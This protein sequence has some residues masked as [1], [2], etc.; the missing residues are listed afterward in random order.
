MIDV[1]GYAKIVDLGFAKIILD[2]SYT[3]C[4]SEYFDVG[5][6]A[7]TTMIVSLTAFVP[8][9]LQPRTTWHQRLSWP[10]DIPTPS[11]IGPMEY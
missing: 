1:T 2:K 11:T 4:G 8:F 9:S 7:C 6:V 3:F 5:C 10:R